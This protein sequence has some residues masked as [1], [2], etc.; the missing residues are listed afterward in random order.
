MTSSHSLQFPSQ[1]SASEN[2]DQADYEKGMVL[3]NDGDDDNGDDAD[4]GSDN[5]CIMLYYVD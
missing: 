2:N 4:A 5:G 1:R 3:G